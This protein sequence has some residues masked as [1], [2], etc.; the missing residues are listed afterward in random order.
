MQEKIPFP[1]FTLCETDNATNDDE[2]FFYWQQDLL[3]HIFKAPT[4]F[5]RCRT[6]N[7][8]EPKNFLKDGVDADRLFKLI[9]STEESE[10]LAQPY[11]TLSAKVGVDSKV[12]H[13][14]NKKAD[15]YRYE[16]IFHSPYEL[17]TKRNQKFFLPNF[18]NALFYVTPQ[19]NT[20]DDTMIAMDPHE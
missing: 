8:C 12:Y 17:P 19:F 7:F 16:L 10:N 1:A 18:D 9:E 4:E 15:I 3:F 14:S 20:I 5:P 13:N 2:I 6:A 11:M